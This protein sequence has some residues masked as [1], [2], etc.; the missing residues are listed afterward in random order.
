M[1]SFQLPTNFIVNY[2]NLC[3]GAIVGIS[4]ERFFMY[5]KQLCTLWWWGPSHSP[6]DNHTWSCPPGSDTPESRCRGQHTRQCLQQKQ[7]WCHIQML[8]IPF[9]YLLHIS[10]TAW[11]RSIVVFL[12]QNTRFNEQRPGLLAVNMSQASQTRKMANLEMEQDWSKGLLSN[13]VFLNTG[14]TFTAFLVYQAVAWKTETLIADL[15]VI[16]GVRAATIICK[17]LVDIWGEHNLQKERKKKEKEK[18][19]LFI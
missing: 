18:K 19:S 10:W 9:V 5:Q 12:L 13:L 11:D 15:E 6:P 4:R 14:I 7:T 8:E 16:T 1:V 3:Y 2:Q 17:A